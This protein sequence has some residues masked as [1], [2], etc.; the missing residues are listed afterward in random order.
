MEMLGAL[1]Q[2][3]SLGYVHRDVKPSNFAL[4][5]TKAK[6]SRIILIDF[7]LCRQF[8]MPN[9][10]IKPPRENTQFRFFKLQR[11]KNKIILGAFILLKNIIC[12]YA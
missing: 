6:T 1:E 3:H 8:R 7:G 2:L 5:Q 4:L 12:F 11:F 10:E 9:G